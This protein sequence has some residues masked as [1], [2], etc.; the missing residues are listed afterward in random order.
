MTAKTSAYERRATP[1]V[2]NV[3]ARKEYMQENTP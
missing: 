2:G 3:S 1:R